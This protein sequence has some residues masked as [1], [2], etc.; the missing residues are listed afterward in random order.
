MDPKLSFDDHVSQTVKKANRL[1][2]MLVSNIQCKEKDIM[3]PLFKALVRPVL[4]YGNSVWTT[5]LKKHNTIIENVQRRFTKKDCWFARIKTR[6]KI[7]NHKTAK[8]GIQ[9]TTRRHDRD[10]QNNSRNI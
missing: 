1:C 6:I 3:V 5:C 2:G 9:E 8:S 10:L 4:E 7:R